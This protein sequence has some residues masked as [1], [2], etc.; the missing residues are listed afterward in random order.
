ME[1]GEHAHPCGSAFNQLPGQ[2][3]VDRPGVV[4]VGETGLGGEGVRIQPV[5]K[6][7]V[8]AHPQHG[9]LGSVEVEI[10]RGLQNQRVPVIRRRRWGVLLRQ[11]R[12]DPGDFA[13]LRHEIAVFCDVQLPQGRSGD[14]GA[15]QNGN[16]HANNSFANL[17]IQNKK[18]A[19]PGRGIP[20]PCRHP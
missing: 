17:P 20:S 7:Q 4:R 14:D 15:F 18:A 1:G 8:H 3:G 11:D 5:Q 16:R 13:V 12:E 19:C 2:L 10:R 9:I 6:R